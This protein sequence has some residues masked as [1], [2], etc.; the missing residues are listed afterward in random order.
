MGLCIGGDFHL[1]HLLGEYGESLYQ[2][3][4]IV[5]R[6]LYGLVITFDKRDI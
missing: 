4:G 1:F 5:V 6:V 3:G 2:R